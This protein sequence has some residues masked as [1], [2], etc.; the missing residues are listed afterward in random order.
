M[1]I[2]D[3][4]LD[5]ISWNSNLTYI[6][7]SHVFN[8]V[9]SDENDI[10]FIIALRALCW[11]LAPFLASQSYTQS[12]G[13]LGWGSASSKATNYTQ[14]NTN[15]VNTQTKTHMCLE[16]DASPLPQVWASENSSCL[17]PRSNCYW[18]VIVRAL[19]FGVVELVWL[20][21]LHFHL[22]TFVNHVTH[23]A[24]FYIAPS[25]IWTWQ[26]KIV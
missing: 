11:A 2:W 17:R 26:K 10:I 3:I 18:Q 24:A 23:N 1:S 9:I 6:S 16:W 22:A 12:V 19:N 21:L 13:L 20:L 4:I 15:R 7:T 25:L 8:K 5:K 14:D